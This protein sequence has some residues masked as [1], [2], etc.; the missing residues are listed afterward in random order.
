MKDILEKRSVTPR[1]I[2][3]IVGML[4]G[5]QTARVAHNLSVKVDSLGF[6]SPHPHIPNAND[7]LPGIR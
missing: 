5:A 1:K 7:A 6:G 4:Q 3:L 2:E